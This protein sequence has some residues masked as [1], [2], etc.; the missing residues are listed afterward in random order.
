MTHPAVLQLA[1]MYNLTAAQIV[2]CV[3]QNEGAIPLS[4][5][6]NE[7]HMR[8]DVAVEDIAFT[9]DGTEELLQ[10]VREFIK[11]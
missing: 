11:R 5:T 2:Y 1:N 4:G 8:E 10:A 3:A 7:V 6:T 9:K